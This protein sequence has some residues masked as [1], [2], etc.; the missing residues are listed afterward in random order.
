MRQTYSNATTLK[1]LAAFFAIYVIWGSTYLAIRFAVESLPPLLMMGTRHLTAGALLLGFLFLRGEKAP[2]RVA[3][4]AALIGGALQFLGGHGLLAWAE[5]RVSSGLAA[6]LV[7]SEP[8]VMVV[9]ARLAGQERLSLRTV[10]ALAL[11]AVGVA[12]LFESGVRQGSA[13]AAGAVLLAAV[14]WCMGAIYARGVRSGTSTVMFAAMQMLVGGTMLLLAG[15]AAGER[16]HVAEVSLRS[17]EALVYL[18]IFGSLVAFS[19]YTWLMQVTTAARVATHCYV[20]PIVAVFLGWAL[21]GERVT[22]N[23]LVGTAIV[24]AS[25]VL[26]TMS[27]REERL[28]PAEMAAD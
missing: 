25:V 14:L 2:R 5:V 20:N 1:L 12:V 15:G 16:V 3:W 9:L 7:A 28:V 8:L 6:L 19:A 26:V 24:I 18:I 22:S 10:G 21:A 27:K 11:G 13:L 4:G 17:L 23:M